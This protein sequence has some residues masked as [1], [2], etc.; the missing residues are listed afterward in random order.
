MRDFTHAGSRFLLGQ[1]EY[2]YGIWSIGQELADPVI[3]FPATEEGWNS[4]VREFQRMEPYATPIAALPQQSALQL[5]PYAG[6]PAHYVPAG[7]PAVPQTNS[8]ATAGGTI[9]IVGAVLSLIPFAGIVIG[10][11]MGALAIVFGGVGLGR[12]GQVGRGRGLAITGLVLGILTV[13]FKLI[14]GVDLL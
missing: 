1:S 9:G 13:I 6:V 10:L 8:M 3:G 14:P 5:S 12:A 11:L 2:G 4:A 7:A